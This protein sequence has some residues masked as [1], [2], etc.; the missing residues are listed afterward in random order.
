MACLPIGAKSTTGA[1]YPLLPKL[2]SGEMGAGRGIAVRR[3]GGRMSEGP[4]RGPPAIALFRRGQKPRRG[5]GLVLCDG[6]G[7][8]VKLRQ[9]LRG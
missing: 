1:V 7:S 3:G 6:T 4:V 8:P 5:P 2:I 9:L